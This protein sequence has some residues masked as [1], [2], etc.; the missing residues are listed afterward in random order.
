MFQQYQQLMLQK[1]VVLAVLVHLYS[2]WLRLLLCHHYH[3]KFGLLAWY[4]FLR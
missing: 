2:K 1:L 3:L 4:L